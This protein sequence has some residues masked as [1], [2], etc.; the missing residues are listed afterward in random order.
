M[1]HPPSPLGTGVCHAPLPAP[2]S[3]S[4]APWGGSSHWGTELSQGAKPWATQCRSDTPQDAVPLGIQGWGSITEDPRS[5][6]APQ[7]P[8]PAELAVTMCVTVTGCLLAFLT[9]TLLGFLGKKVQAQV[10]ARSSPVSQEWLTPVSFG[11]I[12]IHSA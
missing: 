7:A 6:L 11:L 8:Q 9:G 1:S 10:P 12:K 2:G 4:P 5:L 3:E